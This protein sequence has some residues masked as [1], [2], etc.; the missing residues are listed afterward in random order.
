MLGFGWGFLMLGMGSCLLFVNFGKECPCIGSRIPC[1]KCKK[2]PS[3]VHLYFLTEWFFLLNLSL[4]IF[5]CF[6]VFLLKKMKD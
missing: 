5:D 6:P 1:L 2:R 3:R 4:G